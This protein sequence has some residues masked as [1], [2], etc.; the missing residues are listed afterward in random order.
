MRNSNLDLLKVIACIGVVLLHTTMP[1][2]KETGAWNISAYLYYLGTYS[3]P[4]F[5]MVNGFLLLNRKTIDFSYILKKVKGILL[6]VAVWNLIIWICRRDFS[7]N[8]I[9]KVIGS[10]VQKGYF[11]QFW[12]FGALLIIYVTLPYIKKYLVNQKRYIIILLFLTSIGLLFELANILG[13][14]TFQSYIP[15]TFRL[16][17]WYFYYLV[18]GY[19]GSLDYASLTLFIK[20]W[21]KYLSYLLLFLS[22]CYLYLM[23]SFVHHNLFAEYFYDSLLVKIISIGVFLSF[24]TQEKELNNKMIT[25]IS[26]LTMGV[27]IIHTYVIKLWEKLVTTSFIGYSLLFP[28]IILIVSFTLTGILMRIPY[29]K[30]IVKL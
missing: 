28:L 11:F 19:I 26:S 18:G 24:I 20:S 17:T 30:R 5:F 4:L 13:Q 3:I 7:I 10:L 14:R 29:V 22:P 21:G 8:P 12:F 16:W 6:T 15:Q 2:F 27:F 25:Q 1:G 9:K 23:A